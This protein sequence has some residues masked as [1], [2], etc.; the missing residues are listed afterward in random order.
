MCSPEAGTLNQ[1]EQE[2]DAWSPICQVSDLA[3]YW[4]IAVIR[5]KPT[6]LYESLCLSSGMEKT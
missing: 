3:I 1:K 4:F 6:N 5:K 2:H